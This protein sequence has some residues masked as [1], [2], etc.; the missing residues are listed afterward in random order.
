VRKSYIVDTMVWCDRSWLCVKDP[1]TELFAYFG[2]SEVAQNRLLCHRGKLVVTGRV[3]DLRCCSSQLRKSS[4]V[5]IHRSGRLRARIVTCRSHTAMAMLVVTVIVHLDY[6]LAR[7][8]C[9]PAELRP[10]VAI[11]IRL[12]LVYLDFQFFSSGCK[13]KAVDASLSHPLVICL[14][15]R[16]LAALPTRSSRVTHV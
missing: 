11:R 14:G 13:G 2:L 1:S 5:V 3:N 6:R 7:S 12:T 9:L 16:D 10:G 15:S 4:A 8:H